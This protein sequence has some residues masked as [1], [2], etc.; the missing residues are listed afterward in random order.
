[1]DFKEKANS[2][3]S[4]Y[5]VIK[6]EIKKAVKEKSITFGS[7]GSANIIVLRP[8]YVI[9]IIPDRKNFLLKVKP[10]NDYLESEI[11]KKLT[12]EYL[13]TNKTPHIVGLY[14]KYILEDIIIALPHKCLTLDERLMLPFR[15]KDNTIERLCDFKKSYDEKHI[16]KKATVLILENSPTTIHEQLQLLLGKKQKIEEKVH[17]FNQFIKRV[18]FQFMLTLGKIQQ[19]Y[20]DFIHN[21][22]FL[23]NILAVNVVEFD[24]T[25]Y[26]EYNHLGKKYYLPANGIYIKINDFGYSLNLLKKNSTLENEIKQS[27][28]NIFEIKNPLRDTY[29]FLFDL[30]DGP[31]LG[32]QSVKTLIT[33][34]IKV[35]NHKKILMANFKKQIG[36]FFN[37]KQIDKIHSNNS[38]SLD[39]LWNISESKILMRTVKKPNDYFKLELFKNLMILPDNCRVI[40]IYK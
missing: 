29:T 4:N 26:V 19:D 25:D 9:K 17:N 30:Y 34:Q 22:L 13:L 27:L 24:I 1:M 31:G 2:F 18:I 23:R 8:E 32:S 28:N 40:K 11:Y 20:P 14:K 5:F 3:I 10:N 33:N 6:K 38:N 39:W 12:Q 16:D 37:Y 35:P 36:M 21:D 15:K 7:G